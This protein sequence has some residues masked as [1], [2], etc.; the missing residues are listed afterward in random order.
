MA[1]NHREGN[2]IKWIGVRPAHDGTQVIKSAYKIN[3]TEIIHTVT[4]GKTLYL[5]GFFFES[6]SSVSG[7]AGALIVRNA[8]DVLEYYLA[9]CYHRGASEKLAAR[10]YSQPI[11]I[12]A[13]YD[14]C[15]ISGALTL[16]VLAEIDGWEE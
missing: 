1:M 13:G 7:V 3:G 4:A 5:K 15:I 10:D 14:I 9:Y 12:P 6:S 11:E 8:L 2:R 16:E